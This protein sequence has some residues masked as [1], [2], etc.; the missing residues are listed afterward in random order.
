MKPFGV[1]PLGE[2]FSVPQLPINNMGH[3]NPSKADTKFSAE[4][5]RLLYWEMDFLNYSDSVCTSLSIAYS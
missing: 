1:A 4:D 3:N 2:T 5:H